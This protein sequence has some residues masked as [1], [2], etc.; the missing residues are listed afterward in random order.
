[1]EGSSYVRQEIWNW[2]SVVGSRSRTPIGAMEKSALRLPGDQK[3]LQLHV[4]RS[5]QKEG[6]SSFVRQDWNWPS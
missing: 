6:G 2:S 4:N 5:Q 1:K 3:S